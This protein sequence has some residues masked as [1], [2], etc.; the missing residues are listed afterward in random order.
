MRRQLARRGHE[1]EAA[2]RVRSA[3]PGVI[4]SQEE[5]AFSLLT[6]GPDSVD[7]ADPIRQHTFWPEFTEIWR[8]AK[9]VADRE[10]FLHWEVAFPGV[11]HRWQDDAPTGGFDAV[12]ATRLGKRSSCR[13]SNGFATRSPELALAPT[14]AARRRGI[15]QLRDEGDSLVP[16][17]DAAKLRADRLGQLIRASGH[18]PML[19]AATSTSTPSSSNVLCA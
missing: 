14:A 9:E 2:F 12:I 13:R 3:A 4:I 17:F 19:A 10:N 5:K 15:K 1:K 8:A 11:W 16:E 7:A 6:H 18:Y